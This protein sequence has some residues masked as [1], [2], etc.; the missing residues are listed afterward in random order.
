MRDPWQYVAFPSAAVAGYLVSKTALSVVVQ[1]SV[2]LSS[3]LSEIA[4][5]AS[6]GLLAG[7][8]V[9][10]VIPAYLEKVGNGGGSQSDIGEDVG[11]DIDFGE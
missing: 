7:F 6:S 10:E 9:D 11:G 1:N 5:V 4:V 8:L 3:L 2:G